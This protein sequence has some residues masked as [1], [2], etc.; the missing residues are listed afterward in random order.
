[1]NAEELKKLYATAVA[2]NVSLL[3]IIAV[4][5]ASLEILKMNHLAKPMA[6]PS[7]ILNY[8]ILLFA[9]AAFFLWK[10][11]EEKYFPPAKNTHP[12]IK[13]QSLFAASVLRAAVFEIPALAGFV[14]FFVSGAYIQFYVLAAF[15]AAAI[16]WNFPK[17]GKWKSET[18]RRG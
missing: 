16:I 9:P 1:M 13:A 17:F 14:F 15:S 4:Y 8:F 7:N 12:A 18:G 2:V 11:I 10:R 3:G 5:A 6:K